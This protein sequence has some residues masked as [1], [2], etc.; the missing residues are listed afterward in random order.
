M[1]TLRF[2]SILLIVITLLLY[3][4][5]NLHNLN[6]ESYSP[7]TESQL[8]TS[9]TIKDPNKKRVV[10]IP[11]II[12]FSNGKVMKGRIKVNFEKFIV[13]HS[14]NNIE[15]TKEITF[16]DILTIE[17]KSWKAQSK[18]FVGKTQNRKSLYYFY[19]SEIIMKLKEG[20]TLK[21]KKRIKQLDSFM[22][23]NKYG[24]TTLYT[25]FADIWHI[26]KDGSGFWQNS[27]KTSFQKNTI[28]PET[29]IKIDFF[30]DEEMSE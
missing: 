3:I 17:F 21:Q 4:Q 8:T 25:I 13:S 27:K 15:F 11:A 14:R 5:L 30:K 1:I 12:Y 22:F 16:G 18:R 10:F 26:N 2:F 24:D 7:T 29:V 23:R 19:P 9:T 28:N 6:A 20:F